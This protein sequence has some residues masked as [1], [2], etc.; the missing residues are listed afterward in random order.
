M[1]ASGTKISL[2]LEVETNRLNTAK[3]TSI[4]QGAKKA[5]FSWVTEKNVREL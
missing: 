3:L 5:G 4:R 2:V 1:A